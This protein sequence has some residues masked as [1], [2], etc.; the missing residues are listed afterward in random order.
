M[1]GGLVYPLP[2]NPCAVIS[3]GDLMADET[4]DQSN[5]TPDRPKRT[6]LAGRRFGR[7]TLSIGGETVELPEE[8]ESAQNQPRR[9]TAE[10]RRAS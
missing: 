9:V 4:Y 10:R 7:T 6:T 8:E 5:D 2:W 1:I 3:Q